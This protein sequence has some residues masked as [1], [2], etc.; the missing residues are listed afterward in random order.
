MEGNFLCVPTDVCNAEII[1]DCVFP[2]SAVV[3]GPQS[4]A[5]KERLRSRCKAL[6]YCDLQRNRLSVYICDCNSF[7]SSWF[8]TLSPL[9]GLTATPWAPSPPRLFCLECGEFCEYKLWL[10]Q[11]ITHCRWAG[12]SA[13]LLHQRQ[14]QSLQHK[15]SHEAT[16]AVNEMLSRF[17]SH[18]GKPVLSPLTLDL[19]TC[20]FLR[21]SRD[22]EIKFRN[23][24]FCCLLFIFSSS[25][26]TTALFSVPQWVQHMRNWFNDWSAV[27][28]FA[29]DSHSSYEKATVSLVIKV[30]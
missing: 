28:V 17:V 23:V 11:M 14:R 15:S 4:W 24:Y 29:R 9:R 13:V 21:G 22:A 8:L 7:S 18:I 12:S 1:N 27:A 10:G 2:L 19:S 5:G 25:A 20:V 16:R 3:S 26:D 30:L 6:F